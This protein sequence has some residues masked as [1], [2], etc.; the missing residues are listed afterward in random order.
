MLQEIIT[1]AGIDIPRRKWMDGCRHKC[2]GVTVHT[3]MFGNV[4]Y[5]LNFCGEAETF[6]EKI[7]K[8]YFHKRTNHAKFMISAS[9][10][11][12]LFRHTCRM[13]KSKKI[14]DYKLL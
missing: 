6:F 8:K 4:S 1:I 12:P 14:T 5:T 13:G 11:M 9:A 7:R 10:T 2:I 3:F